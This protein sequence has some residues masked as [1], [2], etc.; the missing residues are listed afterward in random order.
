MFT[1]TSMDGP[2]G[3]F[4]IVGVY[5]FYKA[6]HS[7][8]TLFYALLTGIALAFGM[9]MTY[10][11]VF[12]GLFMG[13]VGLLTLITNREQ[14]TQL[15]KVILIA[16]GA[17][18]VFYLLLFLITGFNLLEAMWASIKKDERGMGTGY[19]TIGRYF[20]LS[21]ANLFALPD[22]HRD[23]HHNRVDTANCCHNPAGANRLGPRYLRGRLPRRPTRNHLFD[24]VYNGGRTHLDFYGALYR[25]PRREISARAMRTASAELRFLLGRRIIVPA[26]DSV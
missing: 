14:F 7:D 4:P 19:E 16:A 9:S 18:A 10:S 22:W 25:H 15:L 8:R 6:I 21:F 5:L 1:T 23:S 13:S 11:T 26:I 24:P 20:H 2:F 12:I 3:V 17:F